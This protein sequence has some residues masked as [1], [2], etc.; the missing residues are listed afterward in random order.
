MIDIHLFISALVALAALVGAAAVISAAILAA[1][2]LSRPGQ[3]PRGGTR[4]DLPPWPQHDPDDA[5]TPDSEEAR[6]L[7]LV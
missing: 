4:H 2:R 5:R 3:A 7:V 1:T 6:D